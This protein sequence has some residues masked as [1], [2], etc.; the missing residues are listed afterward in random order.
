MSI[1][2]ALPSSGQAGN[3]QHPVAKHP[4]MYHPGCEIDHG[5]PEPY[6]VN[7][8]LRL[9]HYFLAVADELHFGR[10]AAALYVSQPALSQQIRKLEGE[11][12]AELFVRDRRSVTLTE[13][14]Q[15]L[16]EPARKAVA[17]SEEFVAAARRGR[18]LQRRELAVGFMV[19]WP[20]GFSAKVVRAYRERRPEV[21]VDVR[22]Y[23]FRDTTVG[24]RS[25]EM[26]V[27]L[28]HLPLSWTGA[29][30]RPLC[31]TRRL[32]MLA[33]G[34]PLAGR[35][36]VSLAELVGT[37]LPWAIPP[38]EADEAWRAFWSASTERSAVGGHPAT[39]TPRNQE[40]FFD[41]VASGTLLGLT[42][43][44]VAQVYRPHGVTFVPV[45][46]LSPATRAVGWRRDDTRDDVL[47]MVQTICEVA[48]VDPPAAE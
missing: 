6:A 35:D 29:A 22:Q 19:R 1:P 15:G 27:S 31:T 2:S 25:G 46:D 3:L 7:V 34:H 10:A 18:R 32:V 37:G 21:V 23:D 43:E 11:L 42:E 44:L 33:E 28:L 40:A 14:G 41:Q 36:E 4:W 16:L 24:L 38:P 20:D 30:L 26:D 17:A 5:L 8:D 45:T 12:G 47:A 13:S 9:L 39:V 48:G